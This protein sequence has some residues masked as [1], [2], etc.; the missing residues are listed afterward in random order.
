M[1]GVPRD[2][3]DAAHQRR[4]TNALGLQRRDE[5][6]VAAAHGLLRSGDE[7]RAA[8]RSDGADLGGLAPREEARAVDD[9]RDEA[10]LVQEGEARCDLRSLL[11]TRQDVARDLDDREARRVDGPEE[12]EVLADL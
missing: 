11:G 3:K 9:D 6:R 12:L 4:R 8:P 5:R 1:R 7:L 2:V 10:H